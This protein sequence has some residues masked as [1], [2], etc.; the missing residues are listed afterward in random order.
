MSPLPFCWRFRS[1]IRNVSVGL[2]VASAAISQNFAL[3]A[4]TLSG[5]ASGVAPLQTGVVLPAI[6]LILP[7]PAC[8]STRAPPALLARMNPPQSRMQHALLKLMEYGR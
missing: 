5:A 3:V 2:L 7:V 1:P 6:V 8:H 4:A